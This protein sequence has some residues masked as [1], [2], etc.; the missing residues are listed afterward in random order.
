MFSYSLAFFLFTTINYSYI[1]KIIKNSGADTAEDLFAYLV[2]NGKLNQIKAIQM[3]AYG[4]LFGIT[5]TLLFLFV[6][7]MT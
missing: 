3:A 4:L 7:L 6:G 5:G 2:A 1:A